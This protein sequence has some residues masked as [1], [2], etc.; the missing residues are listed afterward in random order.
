M[1]FAMSRMQMS[2]NV[3]LSTRPPRL[4]CEM[5]RERQPLAVRPPRRCKNCNAP[6]DEA[7]AGLRAAAVGR[8]GRELDVEL[9]RVVQRHAV[10][11]EPGGLGGEV[12]ERRVADAAVDLTQ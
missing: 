7:L 3:M 12:D 9:R 1:A 4:E 2:R 5:G 11:H 8:N 10:E 6:N